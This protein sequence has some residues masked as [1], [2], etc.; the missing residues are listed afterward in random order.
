MSAESKSREFRALLTDTLPFELPLIFTNEIRYAALTDPPGDADLAASMWAKLQSMPNA[1]H[2]KY[3]VPYSYRIRKDRSGTTTLGLIHPDGQ[4]RIAGFYGSYAETILATC[5]ISKTS[6]RY[7]SAVSRIYSQLE[8]SKQPTPKGG[9]VHVEPDPQPDSIDISRLVSFFTYRET[10]LLSKFYDSAAYIGLEKKFSKLR[11]LDVSRCFYNIY[12]HSV[13]WAVKSKPFAKENANL[14]SFEQQ[15]D[16]IMQRVNYNE[17]NGIVVGPEFS[18]IF[19]EVIFQKIDAELDA[20]AEQSAGKLRRGVDYD[21]RRYVD[22]F[23]VYANDTDVLDYLQRELSTILEIYKLYLN[24][25]KIVDFERP[26]VTSLSTARRQVR[27]AMFD[28][29]ASVDAVHLPMSPKEYRQIS[30][31]VR[32][33][34]VE[35]RLIIG[36]H[37]VGFHNISSWSLSILGSM[38]F[39]MFGALANLQ[40]IDDDR[41]T[42]FERALWALFSLIFY[43]VSLDVRVPTTFALGNLLRVCES[44]GYKRLL[45]HSDWVDHV[46]EKEMIDLASQSHYAFFHKNGNREALETLNILILGAHTHGQSFATNAEV[47]RILDELLSGPS[48]YFIY[49]S[50]KF[51]LLKDTTFHAQRLNDLNEINRRAVVDRRRELATDSEMY[52]LFCDLLSAPD[53]PADQKRELWKSVQSDQPSNASLTAFAEICGFVDWSGMRLSHSLRRKRLRPVYE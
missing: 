31:A 35:T 32:G 25:S 45:H 43:I 47:V 2:Q 23:F 7:P 14:F 48:S 38:V 22:D 39:E 27:R 5:G 33:K 1:K 4:T 50:L 53:I 3:T 41:L 21:I 44:A 6:L 34:T 29:K 51:V 20:R 11:T 17:T 52:H 24:E 13:T 15:L 37:G 16:T 28:L 18:R 8:L 40:E 30:Q 46:I 19:A 26:F 12:T 42:C 10:N 9:E 36:E 49:V